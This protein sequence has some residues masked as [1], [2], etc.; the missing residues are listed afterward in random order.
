MQ[1]T[2]EKT[3]VILDLKDEDQTGEKDRS[4]LDFPKMRILHI[5]DK[6]GVAGL[7]AK[8]QRLIGHDAAVVIQRYFFL[9]SRNHMQRN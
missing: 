9:W 2:E 4:L 7:L 1:K 8:Y 5:C 3:A 6:A